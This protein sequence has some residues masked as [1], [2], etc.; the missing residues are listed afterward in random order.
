MPKQTDKTKVRKQKQAGWWS[1][2]VVEGRTVRVKVDQD[3][4]MASQSCISLAPKVF[5]IDWSK[6]K[7]AFEGAPLEVTDEKGADNETI[8]LAAQSCPYQ[9][10][11]LED[12]ETGERLFP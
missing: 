5:R 3:L 10:I 8:F 2:K 11:V 9:A 7:S 1:G 12:A 6:R 4:C